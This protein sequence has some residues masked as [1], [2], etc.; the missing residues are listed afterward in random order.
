MDRWKLTIVAEATGAIRGFSPY[1]PSI[2]DDG[3]VAFQ[4]S[5]RDGGSTVAI[6]DAGGRVDAAAAGRMPFAEVFSHPVINSA[7]HLGVYGTHRELGRGVFMFAGGRVFQLSANPGPLG[8][9]IADSALLAFREQEPGGAESIC[10]GGRVR[11]ERLARTGDRFVAFQGLPVVR[12]GG[13]VVFRADLTDGRQGIYD[14]CEGE[15]RTVVET[16]ERFAELGRFPCAGTD[17]AVFFVAGLSGG[18]SGAFVVR[19]GVL[20]ELVM[21]AQG[22]S[23]FRG[24][25]EAGRGEYLII[26]TPDGGS[27]GVFAGPD[28]TR[29]R[30]L[31][32]G[33]EFMGS[34]I[35]DFALNPASVNARG[36]L[37]IRLKLADERELIVTASRT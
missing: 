23:S 33:S 7:G 11:T 30:V 1:V 20:T 27:L 12:A 13:R 31:A 4:A 32:I 5:L 29:D 15:I 6:V 25:L 8:P 16:G 14:A 17:G 26:A 34:T 3:R 24:V 22:F 19:E 10:L 37:A 2:D 35:A 18:G 21:A 9:T 36:T 28:P